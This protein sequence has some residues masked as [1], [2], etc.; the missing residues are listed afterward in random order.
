MR[1]HLCQRLDRAG[2]Q[3]QGKHTNLTLCAETYAD[4]RS[5]CLLAGSLLKRA[6]ASK[7]KMLFV[8]FMKRSWTPGLLFLNRESSESL[9]GLLGS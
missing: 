2:G 4:L 3:G 1:G 7:D 6:K 8:N 5:K 9:K